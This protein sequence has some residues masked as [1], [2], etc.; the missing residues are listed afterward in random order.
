MK[1]RQVATFFGNEFVVP[2]NIQ[3]IDNPKSNTYGWQVRFG[4]WVFISDRTNDGSGS[5]ASL[6]AAIEELTRRMKVLPAPTG[7]RTDSNKNKS[8]ELP[9]GISGPT[10]RTRKERRVVQY[11]FQVTYP[12]FGCKPANRSVYIAT[13]NTISQEKYDMA[14]SKATAM[15][16]KG[17]GKFREESDRAMRS[18]AKESLPLSPFVDR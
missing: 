4:R 17:A 3:R 2:K 5:H 13:E 1:T 11:Y 16:E 6:A 8:S 12:V 9:V 18:Q 7:L 10:E 14:L 15:R